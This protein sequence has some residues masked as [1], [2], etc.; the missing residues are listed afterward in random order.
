MT[1][2]PWNRAL[3][4]CLLAAALAWTAAPAPAAAQQA[5]TGSFELFG[6]YLRR[7]SADDSGLGLRAGYRF[8]D[9]WAVEG[10]ALRVND[11]HD[12]IWLGDLSAKFYLKTG[13]RTELFA[14][15]GPGSLRFPGGPS[16]TTVHAGL[17]AEIALGGRTYLRPE[18][19]ARW[20]DEDFDIDPVL[21][22]SLGF[23]WRF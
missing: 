17:G 15:A 2:T 10:T 4:A 16:E 1:M 19:R 5:G 11:S 18:A 21:D 14:L 12:N 8:T 22:Y 3:P 7:D 6:S 9:R 13:G 23:G 20:I